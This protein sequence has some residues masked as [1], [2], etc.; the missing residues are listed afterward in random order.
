MRDA[1]GEA[2]SLREAPLPQ[3]PSPEERLAFEGRGFCWLG[4]ACEVG[5]SLIGWV[6]V[7]AADRAAATCLREIVGDAGGEAASLREAPLPQTPSPE[8]QLAFEGRGFCWL[9]SACE[10]ARL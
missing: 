1:G 5:T 3:T 2:A 4:S 10:V 6:V 8:E 7:T 9:G